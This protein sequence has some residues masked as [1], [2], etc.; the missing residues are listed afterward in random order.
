MAY[1][2]REA[3]YGKFE[4]QSL[5]ADGSTT[6]FTL[7]YTIGSASSILVNVWCCSRSW[8]WLYTRFRWNTNYIYSV[9]ISTDNVYILS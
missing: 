4:R 3:I 1:I 9:T 5:T 6:T 2:G 8:C 7:N